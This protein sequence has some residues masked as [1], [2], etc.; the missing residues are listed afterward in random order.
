[1]RV[2]HL[3]I[4]PYIPHSEYMPVHKDTRLNLRV[5]RATLELLRKLADEQGQTITTY[6][7]RKLDLQKKS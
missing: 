3:A 5:D 6:I 2:L 4:R 7:M 1:M